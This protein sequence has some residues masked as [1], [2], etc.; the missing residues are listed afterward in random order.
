MRLAI[1]FSALGC[2]LIV[3]LVGGVLLYAE[4]WEER[5][6]K[7]DKIARGAFAASLLLLGFLPWLLM[8]TWRKE[9]ILVPNVAQEEDTTTM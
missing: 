1:G 6:G 8:A 5:I 2:M 7:H 3:E 9:A 4:G